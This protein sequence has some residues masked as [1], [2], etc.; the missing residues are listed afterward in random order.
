[1]APLPK[2]SSIDKYIFKHHDGLYENNTYMYIEN[3]IRGITPINE[4]KNWMMIL[5]M[6]RA[7]REREREDATNSLALDYL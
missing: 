1:M 4:Q 7:P 6:D 3:I 5:K 2:I